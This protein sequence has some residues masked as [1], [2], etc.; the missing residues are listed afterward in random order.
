FDHGAG[1]GDLALVVDPAE[2]ALRRDAVGLGEAGGAGG[3]RVRVD[4]RGA[5]D[6]RLGAVRGRLRA[7]EDRALA[8]DV[9]GELDEVGVAGEVGAAEEPLDDAPREVAR[10]ARVAR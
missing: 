6:D 9:R 8:L 1:D 4:A 2:P 3:D 5:P 10:E 7:V